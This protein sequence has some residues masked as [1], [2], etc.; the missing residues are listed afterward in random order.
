MENT[1]G[2]DRRGDKPLPV[3]DEFHLK[4]RVNSPNLTEAPTQGRTGQ[5]A[6]CQIRYVFASFDKNLA[7]APVNYGDFV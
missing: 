5:P 4:T 7:A 3:G 6:F 2:L 1:D